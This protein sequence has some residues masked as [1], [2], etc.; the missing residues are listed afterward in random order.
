MVQREQ[1]TIWRTNQANKLTQV[2][3]RH[4]NHQK[5]NFPCLHYFNGDYFEAKLQ[6]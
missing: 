4:L 6:K 2:M 3:L 5:P 1:Q